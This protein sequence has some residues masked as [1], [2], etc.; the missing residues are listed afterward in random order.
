MT[1]QLR[2]EIFRAC[3]CALARRRTTHASS[4][5][6]VAHAPP[7][8][9]HRLD[10]QNQGDGLH[11]VCLQ[12]EGVARSRVWPPAV[13]SVVGRLLCGISSNKGSAGWEWSER[14]ATTNRLRAWI[15]TE[16]RP[17]QTGCEK[18]GYTGRNRDT[19]QL[20]QEVAGQMKP[21]GKRG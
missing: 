11:I 10:A 17:G 8:A 7:H 9:Q 5:V 15:G 21:A 3:A 18:A 1:I 4:S 13:S 19:A 14:E 2:P 12:E 20:D 6:A 16:V